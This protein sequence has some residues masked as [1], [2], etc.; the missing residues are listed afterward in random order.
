MQSETKDINKTFAGL[1]RVCGSKLVVSLPL[2]EYAG[3]FRLRVDVAKDPF[4]LY[5]RSRSI[6]PR[7]LS[8]F[9]RAWRKFGRIAFPRAARTLRQFRTYVQC[10]ESCHAATPSHEW[11]YEDLL[12]LYR[13]YRSE[14]YNRA[15]I[16][17][18]SSY[19]LIA[20]RVGSHPEEIRNRNAAVDRFLSASGLEIGGRSAIDYGGSDG[21]FLPPVILE[22][23]GEIDIF[24]ASDAPIHASVGA[25]RVCRVKN[26]E[27]AAYDFLMCMHVLEHVGNPL[28]F[29]VE[30]LRHL[31]PGGLAYIEIPLEM[32]EELCAVFRARVVDE[33]F[34]IHE[35]INRYDRTTISTMIRSMNYMELVAE[36]DEITDLG[37]T[38]ASIGRYLARKLA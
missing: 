5:T 32:S 18:E 11:T 38:R 22:K 8:L 4:L 33:P 20:K 7:S 14:S 31:K 29:M 30:A 2:G 9:A 27:S 6:G 17:V 26:L 34:I 24:D 35:H 25:R 16:S 28:A 19:A 36:E 10:C 15:R 1:C 3:F 12:G 13:D 23:Y 37:W 21:R